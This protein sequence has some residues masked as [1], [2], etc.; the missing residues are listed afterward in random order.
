MAA[1]ATSGR[2]EERARAARLFFQRW[3]EQL[4]TPFLARRARTLGT[5][6]ALDELT[7]LAD[8]WLRSGGQLRPAVDPDEGGHGVAMLPDVAAEAELALRRDV[9]LGRVHT[10]RRDVL[11]EIAKRLQKAPPDEAT[12]RECV[13]QLRAHARWLRARY[14]IAIFAEVGRELATPGFSQHDL[15]ALADACVSE[16]RALGWTDLGL[17][18]AAAL[19]T[20]GTPPTAEAAQ[21]LERSVR[22]V[23][24]DFVCFV[25]LTLPR[26]RPTFPIDAT[27]K[28]VDSPPEVERSGRALKRATHVQVTVRAFDPAGA[29][30]IAHRRVLS[31]IGALTVSLPASRI[32]V[33]SE[34]VGVLDDGRLRGCEVEERLMEERRTARPAEVTRILASSWKA[35]ATPAADPLHDAI[36]LRHRALVAADAESRLL[37]LWSGLE[38]LTS[39]ARGFK[40]ALGA[41]KDLVSGAV[42]F[43]KL[44]R[45][46]GDLAASVEHAVRDDA[47]RRGLLELVGG[48]SGTPHVDRAKLLHHLLGDEATLRQLL[49]FFYDDEPLLVQR[50]HA[51]WRDFGSGSVQ[52]RG[53]SVA[54]YHERSRNRVAWQVGRIYRARNRIAHVGVG[55]ERVRDLVGHAH[56]YLTQ[57]VAIC[58][59]QGEHSDARAQDILLDR[60][61]QYQA[62]VQL[63]SKGGAE[64]VSVAALLRPSTLFEEGS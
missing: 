14:L 6:A 28:L 63:L 55:P 41:A 47:K 22:A 26:E 33:P 43:G 29:A 8:S 20:A 53:R 7:T 60:A 51:L 64:P 11:A 9:L 58:V 13:G 12:V 21:R 16:L 1:G 46:V 61:G 39:G 10:A 5:C 4:G 35:S 37:L 36:R 44:R 24:R 34:V 62:F 32:D 45:D 30:L 17:R 23:P 40:A 18:E 3:D 48:Y 56:F 27:F 54:E 15:V 52:G 57:L 42:T 49:T 31:T 25:S 59:H 19:A 38:R 50:C 2:A